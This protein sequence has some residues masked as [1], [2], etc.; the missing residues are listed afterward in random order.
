MTASVVYSRFPLRDLEGASRFDTTPLREAAA[1]RIAAR[2]ADPDTARVAPHVDVAHYEAVYPDIPAGGSDAVLHWHEAGWR[3]RRRPNTWFDTGWYLDANPD[4]R[5]AGIDPLLHYVT[6]GALEGRQPRPSGGGLRQVVDA[7]QAPQSRP[8]GYDAPEDAAMLDA[9]AVQALLETACKGMRGLVVSASHDRSIDVTGGVQIFIADEQMLFNGD[10]FAY[11]HLSPAVARLTLA[12]PDEG[13]V[14]LQL[15]IDGRFVGLARCGDILAALAELPAGTAPARLFVVHSLFGHSAEDIAAL[16]AALEG[17]RF[18][19]LHD[20]ASICEGYNLLRNDVAFCAAPPEDSM[21]CRICVYGGNRPTYRAALR[22][23]FDA[24]GFHVLAPS[25]AALSLWLG[26]AA[27]PHRSAR[28]HANGRFVSHPAAAPHGLAGPVRVAFVGYP[29]AHKGWPLFVELVRQARDLGIY[30][31]FHFASADS[32][33]PMDGLTSIAAQV[34]RYDRFAMV[35]AMR[36]Q[37]IDLV[38]ILSPW[39]ETFSY[40]LH[41]ALAAG[42]DVVTLADSGN[43]ADTVRR[44]D[45][46]VVLRD[47]AALLRFFTD[48]HAVA[49]ARRRAAAGIA[50]GTLRICGTTATVDLDAADGPDPRRFETVDPDL[51][52]LAGETMLAP[53]IEGGC[54]RFVLPE[55]T[56]TVRLVSRRVVPGLLDPQGGD[57]RRLGIAVAQIRLDGVVVPVGDPRRLSGW[58]GVQPADLHAPLGD[59]WEWTSGDA[60]L[61]TDGAGVLEV[62]LERLL[63]YIRVALTPGGSVAAVDASADAA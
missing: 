57:F 6:H 29:M 23:L 11:L 10:R 56:Q 46:G 31:L 4:I 16:A 47:A 44:L 17:P 55:G 19:W 22:R 34:D 30:A 62:T 33:Q 40:V 26:A 38:A 35:T 37:A 41:E 39:P 50:T 28:V 21:A 61:A 14:R 27:L 49:Y 8:R 24:V 36:A 9:S 58:H 5:D 13:P 59:V 25:Q 53:E 48:L 51:H 52:A 60:E 12:E 42:A 15:V 7:A 18:F 45:R 3:E 1:A 2:H 20:Y 32:L 43:V 63:T 54:Y